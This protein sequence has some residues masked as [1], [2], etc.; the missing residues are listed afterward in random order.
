[1]VRAAEAAGLA[2]FAFTEHVFHVEEARAASRYLGTRWNGELEGPP[3]GVEQY[4]SEI[5]DAADAV[6]AVAVTVGLELEHWPDDPLVSQAQD[7]VRRRALGLLGRRARLRALPD[8]R[9]LD[10]RPDDADH[11]HEAWDDYLG[12]MADAIEHGG[13]DVITHPI[14][15]AVSRPGVPDDLAARLDAVADL[16]AANDVGARG[17]RLRRARLSAARR[18]ALRVARAHGREGQPGL[19]RALPAPRRRGARAASSSCTRPAC[20]A[21][22]R[23]R[24][25]SGAT[26]RCD[27]GAP[28]RSGARA[29]RLRDGACSSSRSR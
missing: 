15:L 18:A 27:R 7:G 28:P 17:Q 10:L 21:R 4:L 20:A 5:A 8:R 19:R 3:I 12:R 24:A 2:G 22:S 25:A 11:R 23:S 29:A 14:R 6:P 26:S 16:A 13:Y 9:P 1:M